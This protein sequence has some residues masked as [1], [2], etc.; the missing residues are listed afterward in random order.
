VSAYRRVAR[1]R[2]PPGPADPYRS[3]LERRTADQLHQAQ[4]TALYEDLKLRYTEPARERT[5]TPDWILPNGIIVET[6]GEFLTKDRMKHKLVHEQHP[7]LDIRIVFSNSKNK[8]GKK[9]KT[10]YGMWC[11]RL[12]IP[13]ADAPIP[14]AWLDEPASPARLAAIKRLRDGR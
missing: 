9:S 4:V 10:T 3:G 2:K 12:G 14:Q 5:Y 11:E 13:Y 8:I 6:K 1:G 7:D